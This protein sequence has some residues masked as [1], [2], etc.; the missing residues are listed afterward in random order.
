LKGGGA[1]GVLEGLTQHPEFM[2][3]SEYF[4]EDELTDLCRKLHTENLI[5]HK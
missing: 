4:Y 2:E 1:E 5:N 3:M